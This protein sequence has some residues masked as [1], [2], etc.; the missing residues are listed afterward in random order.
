MQAEEIK[1]LETASATGSA[2]FGLLL[3]NKIEE[4]KSGINELCNLIDGVINANS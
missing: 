2:I 3:Q 4:A 1:K